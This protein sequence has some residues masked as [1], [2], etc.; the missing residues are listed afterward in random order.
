MC[1]LVGQVIVG[2]CLQIF[3]LRGWKGNLVRQSTCCTRMKTWVWTSKLDFNCKS[4]PKHTG[5]QRQEGLWPLLAASSGPGSVNELFRENKAEKDAEEHPLSSSELYKCTQGTGI[6]THRCIYAEHTPHTF[7]LTQPK[8]KKTY[9]QLCINDNSMKSIKYMLCES[10]G[11]Y[12]RFQFYSENDRCAYE[13]REFSQGELKM[14]IWKANRTSAK[15]EAR[16]YGWTHFF[17]LPSSRRHAHT[18]W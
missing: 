16:K 18:A 8:E 9:I 10:N 5:Q 2:Q 17:W 14:F 12:H 4:W 13:Q 3:I 1:S 7:S 11:V 6:C 15:T